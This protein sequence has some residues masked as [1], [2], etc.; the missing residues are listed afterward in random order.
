MSTATEQTL[1]IGKCHCGALRRAARRMS[2]FYDGKLAPVGLRST[3]FSI[4]ALLHQLEDV[5]VNE[6]ARHIGLDRT[7][8]GKN[9]RPLER[10][11]LIAIG[12]SATDGRSRVIALTPK[13]AA[14]LLAAAPLWREAQRQFEASN[15]PDTVAA[16]RE[17]LAKLSIGA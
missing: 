8:A 13:G 15:G 17:T 11:G 2:Q 14:R 12:P 4:L 7:T 6:L 10:D 3:Q 16:L 9:L 5:S 1:G